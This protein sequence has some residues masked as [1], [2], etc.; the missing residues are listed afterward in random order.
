MKRFS[1]SRLA[2]EQ[3]AVH[4]EAAAHQI[5]TTIISTVGALAV[6]ADAQVAEGPAARVDGPRADR[7]V[8]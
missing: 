3:R 8:L 6:L 4:L 5:P 2:V 7:E 1:S